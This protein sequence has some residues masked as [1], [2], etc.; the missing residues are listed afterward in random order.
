MYR[1][2]SPTQLATQ[3]ISYRG[4][5]GGFTID[6]RAAVCD[7]GPSVSHTLAP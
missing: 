4:R 5:D 7:P 3:A 6:K 2:Y 1:L